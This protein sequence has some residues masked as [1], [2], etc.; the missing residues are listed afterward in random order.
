[1]VCA[2][3]GATSVRAQNL[4]TLSRSGLGDADQGH[5]ERRYPTTAAFEVCR[6]YRWICMILLAE[7]LVGCMELL[8][9]T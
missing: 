6:R 1:M 7:R 8:I 3:A 2:L 4:M 9:H 5:A